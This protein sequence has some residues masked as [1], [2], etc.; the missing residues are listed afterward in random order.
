[1][2]MIPALRSVVIVLPLDRAGFGQAR[3][4]LDLPPRG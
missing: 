1:M 4:D 2:N 3:V